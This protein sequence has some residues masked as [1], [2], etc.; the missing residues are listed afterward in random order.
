MKKTV[1]SLSVAATL[2]AC[3][4][5]TTTASTE[6]WTARDAQNQ[7]F[8]P[9]DFQSF[10]KN[11]DGDDPLC[12]RIASEADFDRYFGAAAV[13]GGNKP[14]GPPE[15]LW[16]THNAYLLAR[17]ANGGSGDPANLLQVQRVERAAGS[18]KVHTTFSSPP[19]GSYQVKTYVL[20]AVPKPVTGTVEFHHAGQRICSVR[21]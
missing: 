7:V 9:N 8:G 12:A 20:V 10:V 4:P 19:S 11:W 3:A 16:A 21:T 1:L 5:T 14:F 17:V 15:S 13:M 2:G 6:S 18:V